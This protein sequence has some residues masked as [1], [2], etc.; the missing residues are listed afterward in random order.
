[1]IAVATAAGLVAGYAGLL[2]SF[3]SRAPSGP[4][5][6]LVAAVLY[7]MSVAIGPVGGLLGRVMPRRHLRA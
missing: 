1:M 3:H 7:G 4:A 2:L 5:I 6:I